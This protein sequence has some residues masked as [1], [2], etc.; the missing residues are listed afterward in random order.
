MPKGFVFL[1]EK[2]LVHL[3]LLVRKEV[4]SKVPSSPW[5]AS[6][7][8]TRCCK[9]LMYSTARDIVL[10]WFNLRCCKNDG[11]RT[12]RSSSMESEISLLLSLSLARLFSTE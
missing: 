11:G 8:A 10:T 12:R 5:A 2:L 7:S 4:I 3:G 9:L 1:S 6:N